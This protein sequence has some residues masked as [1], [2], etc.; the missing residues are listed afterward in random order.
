MKLRRI[1]HRGS[2]EA[3][4]YLIDGDL[5]GVLEARKRVLARWIQGA[6][7]QRVER[8][9]AL[10]LPAI[11]R[12]RAD[13]A[14]G[15][16]LS[17]IGKTACLGACP[18]SKEEIAALRLEGRGLV[19]VRG[20][21]ATLHP[22]DPKDTIDPAA[23]IDVSR[24]EEIALEPLGAPPPPPRIVAEPLHQDVRSVLGA[25]IGPEAEALARVRSALRDSMS[26]PHEGDARP[27]ASLRAWSDRIRRIL[28]RALQSMA[29]MLERAT[30]PETV[31]AGGELDD[32]RKVRVV[33]S[34]PPQGARSLLSKIRAKL[35]DLAARLLL[36][37]RLARLI[38]RRHAE[39]ISKMMDMF[40]RGDLADALRHAIPLSDVP[41]QDPEHLSLSP[42]SPR[43]S[44][45]ISANARRS[46][47][48]I[49]LGPSLYENLRRM[50]RAA[51]ERLEREG[52]FE[53]AAFVLI[54][55]L[56]SVEEAVAFLE[57]HGLF[58]LAAQ[59]AE[60]REL[61]PALVVRQW[62]LAGRAERAVQIARRTGAFADAVVRLEATHR[63][64][65]KAL[66]MLWAD[67]LADAGDFAEAVSVLWPIEDARHLA[68]PWI[69]RAIEDG[70]PTMARML[71]KLLQ[72]APASFPNVLARVKTITEDDS[73]EE[74][75]T[76]G[77]LAAH[78]LVERPMPESR[79]VAR[80]VARALM[81]DA[82]RFEQTVSLSDFNRLVLLTQDAALR[83]DLPPYPQK[84]STVQL[85]DRE[86]PR[87]H[88]FAAHDRGTMSVFDAAVLPNGRFLVALGEAGVRLLSRDGKTIK[89]FDE[90]ADRLIVSDHGN[91]AIG[92]VRR[93]PVTRLARFDL[94]YSRAS[95]WCEAPLTAF[96]NTFDGSLWFVAESGGGLED[97]LLALDATAKR[98]EALW[99][100]PC[101][102]VLAIARTSSRLA[103][104]I[105]DAP[106]TGQPECWCWELPQ[107]VLRH[108]FP[109]HGEHRVFQHRVETVDAGGTVLEAR[110]TDVNLPPQGPDREDTVPLPL[111]PAYTVFTYGKQVR[112][113]PLEVD[114]K[115]RLLSPCVTDQWAVIPCSTAAGVVVMIYEWVGGKLCA[116][117]ELFGS[118]TCRL[119]VSGQSL[120]IGDDLGRV[121]LLDLGQG[122][123]LRS[124][125]M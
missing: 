56:H 47:A 11:E 112:D 44:L 26:T 77:A 109:V 43:R 75:Q 82:A 50:Y 41:D 14:P 65:G 122:R 4:G 23:W 111:P 84:S 25:A 70:G 33:M 35:D 125:R 114:P 8:G 106:V 108:R 18:L 90:P 28:G 34:Q 30:S 67:A 103:A 72:I 87:A 12:V 71:V 49:G 6:S 124:L 92:G 21:S 86:H 22:I 91:R 53:E 102:D 10:L 99:Q 51:F 61:P 42:P 107:I 29:R 5:I 73:H 32:G 120:V 64:R 117:I 60:A 13:Q 9:L 19:L 36:A 94:A 104:L 97:R 100:L 123:L 27:R 3:A 105:L 116:R 31:S 2:V 1:A 15:T 37:S 101:P 38:G 66:R 93:G 80:I 20:G 68:R 57:R 121:L 40:E 119:R 110:D 48:S 98:R 79:I 89:H 62:F 95:S 17:P 46:A 115:D 16:P 74:I 78:L 69:E 118:K 81:R 76:R 96:A 24:F 59:I 55:L 52:R 54:E 63:D 45:T 85:K 58:E 83:A 88:V 113:R 7:V 39:Y